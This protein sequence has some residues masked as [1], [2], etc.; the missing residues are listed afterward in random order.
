MKIKIVIFLSFLVSNYVCAM[1]PR[2]DYRIMFYNVENLFDT[3]DNP[4]KE[5]EAFT[6]EGDMHWNIN[7]YRNKINKIAQVI[8]AVGEGRL[9][10][11]IGLCEVENE[12]VLQDLARHPI[13]RRHHY[14]IV[15]FESPDIR[16]IDVALLYKLD[17]F[18]LLG[19]KPISVKFDNP[20]ERKT[21][22]ILYSK[23]LTLT[24]DT[25]H[26]FVN[27]WSS[28]YSGALETTHK[29]QKAARV[30]HYHVDS[31]W[32]ANAQ[33]KILIMGD[34]NTSPDSDV[35]TQELGTINTYKV[36]CDKGLY[37]LSYIWNMSLRYGT[38]K[39]KGVWENID[40]IIVSNDLLCSH[41]LFATLQ[42]AHIFYAPFLVERD[43]YGGFK[44]FRTYIG[45]KYNAGFSD[46]LPIY[47]DLGFYKHR[48]LPKKKR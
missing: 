3:K 4:E 20:N 35:L 5:D 36:S 33:S 18:Q 48:R 42:N 11:M 31:L 8:V 14:E 27:H 47:I 12:K 2:G 38:H 6:P 19:A 29:R 37:N 21:R 23:F 26:V 13:L 1:S 39:H 30:L 25:L 45:W 40:Q 10:E 22:D 32:V 17:A 46:H 16:G 9:P 24:K 28:K 15:H 41:T 7:A 44:P 43:V 34:F